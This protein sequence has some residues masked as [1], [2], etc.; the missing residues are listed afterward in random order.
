[1]R[2]LLL[3][4]NLYWFAVTLCSL[5]AT[6]WSK[7]REWS[8]YG[9]TKSGESIFDV[10]KSYFSHFYTFGFI[11]NG[12]I[13]FQVYLS[14]QAGTSS[15]FFSSL[16]SILS[17][18]YSFLKSS[19]PM[20]LSTLPPSIPVSGVTLP[21]LSL[22]LLQLHLFRRILECS[23]VSVFSSSARMHIFGYI[24]GMSFYALA[25]LTLVV[26]SPLLLP[27]SSTMSSLLRIEVMELTSPWTVCAVFLF[28]LGNSFQSKA[29][30]MLADLRKGS[31]P[32]QPAE[33]KVPVGSLFNYVSCPHYAAEL[34][35][36]ASLLLLQPHS[37]SLVLMFLF[38]CTNLTITALRTHSWYQQ[39]FPN[40]PRRR[41]AIIPLI[42]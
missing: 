38:V 41:K 10:P 27:P 11:F 28:L 26:Q 6:V 8:K 39:T 15:S 42:L 18:V 4:V 34:L 31:D 23:F 9:K 3:L 5:L 29:H 21:A 19:C 20:L 37:T 35:I 13:L 14:L 17:L 7:A 25:S 22:C 36:Y 40:Y 16:S 30:A 12:F 2:T 1:M 33:Y 32:S 24:L